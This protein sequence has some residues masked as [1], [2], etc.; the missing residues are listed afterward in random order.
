MITHRLKTGEIPESEQAVRNLLGDVARA[1]SSQIR[2]VEQGKL[3]PL[4]YPHDVRYACDIEAKWGVPREDGCV[5]T[6]AC[7]IGPL[8]FHVVD[9][10]DAIRPNGALYKTRGSV[11]AKEI[12]QRG[13]PHHCLGLIWDG[14]GRKEITRFPECSTCII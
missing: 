1:G 10:G 4:A 9:I 3:N 12:N 14:E 5:E 2:V 6:H 7:Y 13:L 8:H 11:D